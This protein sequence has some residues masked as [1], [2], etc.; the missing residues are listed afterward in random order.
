MKSIKKNLKTSFYKELKTHYDRL[1]KSRKS[2]VKPFA[3][4]LCEIIFYFEN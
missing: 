4:N 3:N 2:E 1:P